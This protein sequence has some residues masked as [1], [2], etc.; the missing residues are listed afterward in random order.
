MQLVQPE[1]KGGLLTGTERTSTTVFGGVDHFPEALSLLSSCILAGIILV[2]AFILLKPFLL[3]RAD[4][5][6]WEEGDFV[7]NMIKFDLGI[8]L[9]TDPAD[10]NSMIYSPGAF[11]LT[12]IIAWIGGLTKSVAGLR[13]IQAG[14][15]V[16]S[17]LIATLTAAKITHIS[18]KDLKPR[19]VSLWE[20]FTFFGLLIIA[21]APFSNKF[22]LSLHVDA[23]TLL[24]SIFSFWTM[25]RYLRHPSV[26]ALLLMSICPAMGFLTKQFLISWIAVMV[27][28]LLVLNRKNWRR[29][30]VLAA[31]AFAF[32]GIAYAGCYM[33]WGENYRFW[34]FNI[35]GGLRSQIRFAP[36]A[37]S[38]SLTRI[39]DHFVRM[40]P[41]I[42]IGIVG[43]WLHLWFGSARRMLPLIFAWLVLVGSEGFSSGAG[44]ETFYH[45]GPGILIGGILLFSALPAIWYRGMSASGD[46]IGV[47]RWAYAAFMLAITVSVF[48]IVKAIP[49][50][51]KNSPRYARLNSDVADLD[52]YI[53]DIEAEFGNSD[54]HDVLLDVGSWIYLERGFLQKDRA[55]S[56]ADQAPAGI[57][58]NFDITNERIKNRVYTKILL[59]DFDSPYFLYEWSDW[60]RKSGFKENLLA[61][62]VALKTIPAPRGSFVLARPEMRIGPVTV[63]VPKE[64][65]NIIN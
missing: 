53:S 16:V 18:F 42:M 33:T 60:Q 26:Y 56:L 24:V 37:Y 58:Q 65:L 32:I 8:P 20:L 34:A 22:V 45:F 6:M 14:Y 39:A 62:Y 28:F 61:N 2:Y 27:V 49:T 51:D 12:Y 25:V 5:L 19:H 30:I 21:T 36:D 1:I 63:F 40:L 31:L 52:R 43:A 35:M 11:L 29:T 38:I 9:Y 59:H 57:Y 55:V 48:S 15:V 54:G 47:R 10:S 23:L 17:S 46:R 44:W 41:E 3:L 50:G 7:G 64:S 13:L 4:L